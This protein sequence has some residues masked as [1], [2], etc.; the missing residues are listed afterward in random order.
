LQTKRA[1][2]RSQ[3][4]ERIKEASRLAL[5]EA[6]WATEAKVA[7]TLFYFPADTMEG[8]IDNI[9]KPVLDAL[10]PHL[11][12]DDAQVDRVLVQRFQPGNLFPFANPSPTLADA[13]RR[14]TPV[15]YVRVS[16][17]PFEELT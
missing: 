7:I 1:A 15:L 11:Y 12:F 4:R 5:P 6:S 2:S 17:E 14:P 13:I 9:V 3:W 8:D 16:D 10:A